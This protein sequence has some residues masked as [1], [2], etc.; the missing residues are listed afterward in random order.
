MWLQEGFT[1]I[2]DPNGY[3]HILFVIALCLMYTIKDWRKI[4]ILVTAF[5][6]GH[7]ITLALATLKIVKIDSQL[8]EILIPVTI[9]LT[10][11]GNMI[12]P[13]E[14]PRLWLNYIVALGFGLIHGLGFSN[15]IRM[16][17]RRGE[18][19]L[20][21][22]LKFNIGLEIGQLCIV[23]ITMLITWLFVEKAKQPHNYLRIG[24]SLIVILIAA[25]I[26]YGLVTA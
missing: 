19:I 24:G 21:P 12:R 23:L 15:Y 26:L 9:I 17:L 7:S 11:I 8:V 25:E 14:N 22:L 5:T 2:L 10:C 6:I 4:L 1:H 16:G 3:D 18:E 13:A 20:M